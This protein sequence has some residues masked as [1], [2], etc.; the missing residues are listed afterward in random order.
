[1]AKKAKFSVNGY[2]KDLMGWFKLMKRRE[3]LIASGDPNKIDISD[4]PMELSKQLHPGL[5]KAV[6]ADVKEETPST[7]DKKDEVPETGEQSTVW[8][9]MMLMLLAGVGVIFCSRK[10]VWNKGN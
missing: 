2:F 9:A 3:E 7:E 5:V 10:K 4:Y 6:I 1:M 8:Y